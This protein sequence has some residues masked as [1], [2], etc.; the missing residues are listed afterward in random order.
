[1]IPIDKASIKN[2]HCNIVSACSKLAGIVSRLKPRISSNKP[3]NSKK[4]T[5][6]TTKNFKIDLISSTAACT[7]NIRLKPARG[8]SLLALGIMAS[9]EKLIPPSKILPTN[10]ANMTIKNIH[11]NGGTS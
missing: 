1:M 11:S 6:K 4:A 2:I 3:L 7:P 9:H 5:I 8:E 10:A